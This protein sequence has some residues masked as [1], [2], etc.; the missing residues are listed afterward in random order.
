MQVRADKKNGTADGVQFHKVSRAAQIVEM[1]AA[2]IAPRIAVVS[3]AAVIK[4]AVR[5]NDVLGGFEQTL[6]QVWRIFD[7]IHV[8]PQHPVFIVEGV[9]EQVIAALREHGATLGL[10]G[11]RSAMN[12]GGNAIAEIFLANGHAAELGPQLFCPAGQMRP[13]FIRAVAFEEP[14]GDPVVR[15]GERAEPGA[16][17]IDAISGVL[18]RGK[19]QDSVGH[20]PASVT[21]SVDNKFARNLN[22]ESPTLLMQDLC[23]PA[24]SV[25]VPDCGPMDTLEKCL[26]GFVA[27]TVSPDQFELILG[28]PRLAEHEERLRVRFGG[29]MRLIFTDA[30][31]ADVSMVRNM[32][33]GKA[34]APL[35][36]LYSAHLRPF[37]GLLEY[38]L[39]FHDHHRAVHHAGLLGFAADPSYE[40]LHPPPAPTPTGIQCWQAFQ[41]EAITCKTGLFRHGQFD[42]A[43]GCLAGPEFA[44][45]LSRRTDLTLFYEPGPTGERTE[46]MCLR[47]NCEAHYMAAYHEY[48]LARAY[49]GAVTHAPAEIIGDTERLAALVSSIRGMESKPAEADSPRYRMLAALYSRIEEHARSEGWAAAENAQP[50]S[51]PGSLG[52]LLK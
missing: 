37:P 1:D 39:N 9:K 14:E 42:P 16:I 48:L 21:E 24:I 13:R 36:T 2:A 11:A 15:P 5:V 43:Y 35:V 38:C 3:G 28:G 46:A 4:N 45:R 26:E 49:P 44:L 41:S 25:I 22:S 8:Q 18:E 17:P 12:T 6:D 19:H 40:R 30:G 7:D 10:N 50:P 20:F 52:P 47:A 31:D 51:P 32:A 27:Q 23:P 29:G 34:R 33:I